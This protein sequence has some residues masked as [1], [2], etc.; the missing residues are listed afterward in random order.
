VIQLYSR[1]VGVSSAQDEGSPNPGGIPWRWALKTFIPLGFAL[2]L[3][4]FLAE[5]L[6]ALSRLRAS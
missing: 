4:Q 5:T 2:L 1:R 3:A 6:R